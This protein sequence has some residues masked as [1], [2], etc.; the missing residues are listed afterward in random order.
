MIVLRTPKGWTGPD[1]VDGDPGHR[2][3]GARTRCRCPAC[4]T[5]RSTW[6]MLEEWLRSY[7]PEEL[8]DAAGAPGRSWSR[9]LTPDGRPADERDARTP[10]AAC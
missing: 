7:R 1:E 6:R 2:H 9:A 4:G 5:T 3:A 8:F 10:T